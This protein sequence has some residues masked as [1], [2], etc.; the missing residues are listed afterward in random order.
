[1]FY[2]LSYKLKLTSPVPMQPTYDRKTTYE[3]SGTLFLLHLIF[4]IFILLLLYNFFL[5]KKI[6][7]PEEHSK[8]LV[9]FTFS[10]FFLN[11]F[12]TPQFTES[13]K[14]PCVVR[15]GRTVVTHLR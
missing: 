5:I 12:I 2:K 3:S 13:C 11:L 8:T 15:V 14:I 10:V 7:L 6:Y 4:I 9:F 1:M